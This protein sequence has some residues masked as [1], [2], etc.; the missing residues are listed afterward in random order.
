MTSGIK[1][2]ALLRDLTEAIA[3]VFDVV[4][5]VVIVE[6][7]SAPLYCA[8]DAD[9]GHRLVNQ[10]SVW[11]SLADGI[12]R[13][14]TPSAADDM[15]SAALIGIEPL[16]IFR[17]SPASVVAFVTRDSGEFDRTVALVSALA[18]ETATEMRLLGEAPFLADALAEVES[19]VT[20]ADPNLEDSPLIYVNE[21]FTRMTG[22]SRAETLGR[23]CRFLQGNLHDQP[24]VQTL[25]NA[26]A[27]GVECTVVLTNF[28]RNGDLFNNRLRLK[29][30]YTRDGRVSHVIGIQTDVTAEAA[31]LESLDLQSRRY[32]SLIDSGASHVWQMNAA[33]ELKG[34]DAS[35][36]AFAGV[37]LPDKAVD[38]AM[39]R[40]A[41][42]PETAQVFKERWTQALQ[43]I[44]P[45]EVIYPLPA[46]SLSP[47][48]FVEQVAP[49][50]DDDGNLLEWFGV[51]R[52]ITELKR[53]EQDLERIIQTA[54]T[55][56]IAVDQKGTITLAN[57]QVNKIFGYEAEALI[58]LPIEDLLPERNRSMHQQLRHGYSTDP[59]VRRMGNNREVK[60][61]RRDGTEFHA[62]VGLSWF[63]EGHDFRMVAA[64]ND[65]SELKDARAA[66]E[67][68][69]YE[70][71]VTE[72]LSR[73]GFA[74]RLD[75]L[76]AAGT[77]H[78]GS[79]LVSIDI[80]GLREI[81]NAQGYDAGD[82][83]LRE[84]ASRLTL[85]AGQQGLV[86]RPGTGEFLVL[87][88]ASRLQAPGHWKQQLET[89]FDAPIE[90]GGFQLFV[91]AAFGYVRLG[92]SQRDSHALINDAE[93][94][95][96]QSQQSASVVWTQYTRALERKTRDK[97]TLIHQLRQAFEQNE[98]MLFYQPK[99]DLH[100][101]H[102]QAAEALVRWRHPERGF[103]P[104]SVFIPLA[105]QSQLIGPIGEWVLRKACL[106]LRAW[107]EA[108]LPVRPVSIN[109]SL[110]QF[111]LGGMPGKVQQALQ[112][113]NIA[114]EQITLEV[115][116][117]IFAQHSDDLKKDLQAISALGVNLSLD[118]FGTGYSSLSYL[119]DYPFDEIKI[120]KSFVSQLDG[121][122][123]GRAIISAVRTV[124]TAMGAGIVAE[125][126]ET[127]HQAETLRSLGCTVGQGF[128]YS[129]P[130]PEPEWRALLAGHP[131]FTP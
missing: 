82:E 89:V 27:R 14:E 74:I 11:A 80:K 49:I 119:Q 38:L 100:T 47:R 127:A 39:V 65:V 95:L 83:V 94:A 5:A 90:V 59:S 112:D 21:A 107:H 45:F 99:V 128:Y 20:I 91:S 104:P 106:D 26:L 9:L 4:T 130:L 71:R 56:M 19:G 123:Y 111:Q 17:D 7:Q 60:G 29:P 37:S 116:E 79:L 16:T 35:W 92:G 87:A 22:Y 36:F 28:R 118:D 67:R 34:V 24:G 98:L 42:G 85:I 109:V 131:G 15:G 54:P 122:D 69:A 64:V 72:L 86:G 57:T 108:G 3:Q 120:D 30:I 84:V 2:A 78:P 88:P 75:E 13:S 46:D 33:G 68:A 93:L 124:A 101:G 8:G 115:T 6:G 40:N 96:R 18:T 81:N 44:E 117:S 41:M 10:P 12:P 114:P 61:L 110:V 70:D 63:G 55:G 73:E 129:R 43:D 126:V 31:A 1:T 103:I 48:W 51:S 113:F 53:A 23:N 62:E 25:R 76:R 97:V 66:V 121:G 77:L 125:G 102:I 105:E 32:K 52:E 50:L 58:G